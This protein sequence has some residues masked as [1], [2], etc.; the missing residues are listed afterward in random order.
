MSQAAE[1]TSLY[2]IVRVLSF[3]AYTICHKEGSTARIMIV[4]GASRPTHT[5]KCTQSFSIQRR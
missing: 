3:L 1:L 2:G 5:L 4:E